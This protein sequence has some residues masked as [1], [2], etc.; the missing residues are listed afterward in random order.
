MAVA[1]P[2]S[3][4]N[5]AVFDVAGSIRVEFYDGANVR[6][7]EGETLVYVP[8]QSAYEGGVEFFVPLSSSVAQSG[9]FDVYFDMGFAEYGPLVIPY[10]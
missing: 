9:H 10:G 3:F 5:H 4:E 7:G 8:P 6:V 2:L 1:V